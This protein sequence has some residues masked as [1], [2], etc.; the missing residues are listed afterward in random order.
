MD[1]EVGVYCDA[2]A[3][4]F[5]AKQKRTEFLLDVDFTEE[6]C[7]QIFSPILRVFTGNPEKFL[8]V[9]RS[10]DLTLYLASSF[11]E[12]F[13]LPPTL[14]VSVEG[15]VRKHLIVKNIDPIIKNICK[16]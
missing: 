10:E 16:I 7:V 12:A 3:L 2:K 11:L 14:E 8:T 9:V 1:R 6:P 13:S 4:F 5:L 15:L